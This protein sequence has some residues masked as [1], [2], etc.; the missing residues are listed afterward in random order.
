MFLPSFHQP[1]DHQMNI[2]VGVF[3]VL[4]FIVLGGT[5]II[6]AYLAWEATKH[7]LAVG[8]ILSQYLSGLDPELRLSVAWLVIA[9]LFAPW[10]GLLAY[11][12]FLCHIGDNPSSPAKIRERAMALLRE[13]DV[14]ERSRA[15]RR[16]DLLRRSRAD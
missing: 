14:I 5:A 4:K 1:K 2:I 3:R 10:L 7:N 16:Q 8:N 6:F 13:A 9:A 15:G 12:L 11:L